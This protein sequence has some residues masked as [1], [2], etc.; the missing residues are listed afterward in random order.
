MDYALQLF[1]KSFSELIYDDIEA[2]FL[3]NKFETDIIEFKSAH[4]DKVEESIKSLTT[5]ICAF[6]NSN[7]GILVWGAPVGQKNPDRKEKEFVGKLTSIGTTIEKDALIN[8]ISTLIT[9]LPNNIRCTILEKN[10]N[11]VCVFEI[12][13]SEYAPHQYENKYYM[14]IDGQNRPAPHHY[15]EALFKQVRYPNIEG[16]IRIDSLRT[17]QSRDNGAVLRIDFTIIIFNES[18]MQNEEGLFWRVN[19]NVGWFPL[20]NNLSTLL[21]RD[22]MAIFSYGEHYQ[23]P[24]YID[25]YVDELEKKNN[26]IR[27]ALIF[28]GRFSPI[29]RSD[30]LFKL[31]SPFS[32]ISDISFID[33]FEEINENVLAYDFEKDIS[34]QLKLKQILRR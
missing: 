29:K 11:R 13:R 1:G 5:A 33:C 3:T 4:S 34:K 16:F 31:P 14:R 21:K 18:A 28:G 6:C 23:Y 19:T 9:P 25:V 15:I 27:L 12:Q 22:A 26:R 32:T 30:Y 7:G 10:G 20:N 24:A 17:R 2:Y 8:K